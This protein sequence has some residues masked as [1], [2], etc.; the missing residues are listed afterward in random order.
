MYQCILFYMSGN[1][2]E[3]M[4]TD[5]LKL[6]TKGEPYA[7]KNT[8]D[9]EDPFCKGK[10]KVPAMLPGLEEFDRIEDAIALVIKGDALRGNETERL[11]RHFAPYRPVCVVSRAMCALVL[12]DDRAMRD[13][14]FCDQSLR[15]FDGS[16]IEITSNIIFLPVSHIFA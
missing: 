10:T 6:I 3:F 11:M 9:A 15:K 4:T 13:K 16:V 12:F 5:L 7:S 14:A 1:Y 8:G 2:S